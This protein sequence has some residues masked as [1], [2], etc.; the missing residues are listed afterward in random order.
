MVCE[1]DGNIHI[2]TSSKFREHNDEAIYT[3]AIAGLSLGSSHT[4]RRLVHAHLGCGP[5][6]N[7]KFNVKVVPN[8]SSECYM[9]R[10]NLCVPDS[11]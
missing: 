4:G 11:R 7:Q 9:P 1:V 3:T 5:D 8:A 6:L 10:S 2:R